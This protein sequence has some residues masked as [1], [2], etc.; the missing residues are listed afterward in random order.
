RLAEHA[1]RDRGGPRKPG[2]SHASGEFPD[3]RGVLRVQARP[4]PARPCARPA[5]HRPRRAGQTTRLVPSR[6][7]GP[8]LLRRARPFPADL[9]RQAAA[10]D[11][12]RRDR[13]GSECRARS[14]LRTG[15]E[16]AAPATVRLPESGSVSDTAKLKLWAQKWRWYERNSLPWNR[17]RIHWEF[18]RREAFVRWPIH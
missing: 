2:D 4:A 17:V 11:G 8:S 15:V 6:R 18:M 7:P 3:S 5:R 14:L 16:R 1:P 12:T 13:V 10:R 9:A